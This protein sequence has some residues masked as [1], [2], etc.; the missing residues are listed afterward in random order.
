MAMYHDCMSLSFAIRL[1]RSA[2]HPLALQIA[3]GIRA[4]IMDGRLAAGAR[5]PSWN[6]LAAQLGVARGTVR[7]A[8]EALADAQLV[9]PSGA[10][11]TRVAR[12]LPAP[13]PVQGIAKARAPF[14]TFPSGHTSPQPFQL[15]VPAADLFPAALWTRL[16]AR[17][18]RDTA[19]TA[20]A[21]PDPCG[22][23]ALRIEVAAYLAVARGL[24]CQPSQVFITQGYSGALSAILRALRVRGA[25]A[26][27][28]EPGYPFAR[29]ALGWAGLQP[30]PVPVDAE[31]IDVEAGRAR[32]PHAAIAL[33]TPGQ[34]A[35]LGTTMSLERRLALLEW[36]HAGERWIIEDDYLGELQLARRAAPALASMD[37]ERVIHIGTFSKTLS[38]GLRMGYA[39][40]PRRLVAPMLEVAGTLAPAPAPLL[41][42]AVERFLHD[43][44]YLRHLRRMKRAY[45][46]RR[47][48]LAAALAAE[49]LGVQ[50]AGLALCLPL[51]PGT[52]D[53]AL[54]RA[55]HA[56]ELAPIPLSPWYAGP[57]KRAGFLLGVTNVHESDAMQLAA[58]LAALVRGATG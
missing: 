34:Q 29:T 57:A 54:A 35:P 38:P 5:L 42:H 36:A 43:G 13:R 24:A 40:L 51:P 39:V 26:W 7:M 56:A 52:N 15:G 12:R 37:A 45:A 32:A 30:V 58:R 23:A 47:D 11:G 17:A 6:D 1:E 2:R 27:F 44:H 22:E 49:G 53:V 19:T 25:D 16:V 46:S 3:D 21:Y 8:Y 10:A 20:A 14:G 48:A 55:A 33:V 18:A 28:E 4:A 41:Q 50:G 9:V 31:G